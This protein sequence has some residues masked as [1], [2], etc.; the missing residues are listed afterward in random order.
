MGVGGNHGD[1]QFKIAVYDL[2]FSLFFSN[3]SKSERKKMLIMKSQP[4]K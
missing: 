1:F 4:Q 2:K 3:T